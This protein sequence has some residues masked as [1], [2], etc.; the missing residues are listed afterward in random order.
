MRLK[1]EEDFEP[2]LACRK[3]LLRRTGDHAV[4]RPALP[5]RGSG[6]T[7]ARGTKSVLDDEWLVKP[8]RKPFTDYRIRPYT[9]FT[10]RFMAIA[11]LS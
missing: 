6:L 2:L 10:S 5:L 1:E 11:L 4:V 8:L 7:T 9:L 3:R